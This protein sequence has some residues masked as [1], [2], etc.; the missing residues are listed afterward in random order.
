MALAWPPPPAVPARWLTQA[1]A[2][3]AQPEPE[4]RPP[5]LTDSGLAALC[6]VRQLAPAATVLA[7]LE[8]LSAHRPVL[9]VTLAAAWCAAE[10]CADLAPARRGKPTAIGTATCLA[11]ALAPASGQPAFSAQMEGR[12]WRI[13]GTSAW[14]GADPGAPLLVFAHH[15]EAEAVSAFLLPTDTQGIEPSPSG[16][17]N[18]S[19]TLDAS[20]RPER[21]LGAAGQARDAMLRTD[22]LRRLAAAAQAT[23]VAL[24]AFEI[25]TRTLPAAD[26]APSRSA[27]ELA[28]CASALAAVRAMLQEAG[29]AADANQDIRLLSAMALL[30][31]GEAAERMLAAALKN[32]AASASV[33]AS[34]LQTLLRS[35]H[36]HQATAGPLEAQAV[37]LA[38]AIQPP[39]ILPSSG[40]TRAMSH[41][42]TSR[43]D[44]P[45]D[46]VAEILDAAADAFTQQTYDTTTLDQ[47]GEALGV[48]KGSIY[49]HYRSKAHLFTAVYQ[50]A[51]EMN[52]ATVEPIASQAG[53]RAID[54][55]YRMAYAHAMQVMKHL[56]YQRV[57]VQGLESHL[58]G[59]INEEQR[60]RLAEVIS[61]RD[62]YEEL[63]VNVLAQAIEAGELPRQNARL[64]AKPL[65]GAINWTTMWYQPRPGE[66]PTDRDRLAAHLATFVLSGLTQAYQ[67]AP[68]T[69]LDMP[70]ET[71]AQGQ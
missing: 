65:F 2:V 45:P 44:E 53:V 32:A 63:F 16:S 18:G 61:L 70:A 29:R 19:V 36:L 35:R 34:P 28:A 50:R 27:L 47:I 26:A 56:S 31:A 14:I 43:P 49:H 55:L 10:A 21:L 4:G 24:A 25:A 52:I 20:V 5:S 17:A 71:T 64:A 6:D 8:V 7:V 59:R 48:T 11:D 38:G 1:R 62:H 39:S 54:R 66:T 9:S 41:A 51:L 58:M 23:G 30:S 3:A 15:A 57:A 67:P 22:A 12:A 13:Q 69:L 37:L 40:A 33:D 68:A 42:P 46:R 60:A